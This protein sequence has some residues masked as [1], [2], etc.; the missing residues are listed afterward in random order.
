MAFARSCIHGQ[1]ALPVIFWRLLGP[2]TCTH[3]GIAVA[4]SSFSSLSIQMPSFSPRLHHCEC[5]DGPN[6][7]CLSQHHTF[8]VFGEDI[9][10]PQKC[11]TN[12]YETGSQIKYYICRAQLLM[13]KIWILKIWNSLLASTKWMQEGKIIVNYFTCNFLVVDGLQQYC[14]VMMTQQFLQ[15]NANS[16]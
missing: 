10:W 14:T 9:G 8:D 2:S 12:Q 4:T 13:Q 11:Q 16:C 1:W 6:A 15:C 7:L 5:S 3:K